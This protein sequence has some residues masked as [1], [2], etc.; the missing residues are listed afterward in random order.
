MNGKNIDAYVINLDRG[1]NG[2]IKDVVVTDNKNKQVAVLSGD[3][4]LY[5]IKRLERVFKDC[6]TFENADIYE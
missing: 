2:E 1:F 5:F 3:Q 4:A 6:L